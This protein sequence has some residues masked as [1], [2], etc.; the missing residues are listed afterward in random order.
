MLLSAMRRRSFLR[1]ASFALATAALPAARLARAATPSLP[2]GTRASEILHA[3]PGKRALIK[4]SFRPPNYETPVALLR[5]PITPNDAFYVRWHMGVPDVAAADW[6]LA[7]GGPAARSQRS[8]TLADLR[9][10]R[11]HEV[12]AVNQC[13]G[14]RRGFFEPHVPG[15]QWGYGAMGNARWRGARLKDILERAGLAKEALEISFDGA[16]GPVVEKTPDF[17]KSTRSGRRSTPT[18]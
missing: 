9:R 11:A 10:F 7:I 8:L 2:A 18:R 13:S 16:D 1:D 6:R 12:V 14:N 5:E 3:L 4:P 17:V 15:V